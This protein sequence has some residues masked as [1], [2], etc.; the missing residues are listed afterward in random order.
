M[1]VTSVSKLAQ[2]S[3]VVDWKYSV[4]SP[5]LDYTLIRQWWKK[6]LLDSHLPVLGDGGRHSIKE[7][8]NQMCF[9]IG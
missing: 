3:D 2:L 5:A 8:F 9:V 7:L 6:Y 4:L 1:G